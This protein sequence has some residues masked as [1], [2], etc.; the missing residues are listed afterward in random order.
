MQCGRA[1]HNRI[2]AS[3]EM[4]ASKEVWRFGKTYHMSL[5]CLT[6]ANENVKGFPR[7]THS[8]FFFFFFG[9]IFILNKITAGPDSPHPCNKHYL[10]SWCCISSATKD[11]GE[12]VL[13]KKDGS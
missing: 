9:Q 3:M 13:L 6:D 1:G 10:D 5:F 11:G 8:R 2:A 4:F 7:P 12:G